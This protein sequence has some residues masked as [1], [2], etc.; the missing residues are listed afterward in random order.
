MSPASVR[1]GAGAKLKV[2]AAQYDC[3]QI[4]RIGSFFE[5]R[6]NRQQ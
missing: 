3:L 1:L 2:R 5:L 4:G 6:E